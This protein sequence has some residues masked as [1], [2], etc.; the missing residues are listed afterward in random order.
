MV[1]M[2]VGTYLSCPRQKDQ[3]DIMTKI[4][5]SYNGKKEQLASIGK[6]ANSLL[7]QI[8]PIGYHGNMDQMVTML[9]R[10]TD[11]H[12]KREQMTIMD[13]WASWL[14]GQS[15]LTNYHGKRDKV[16]I[17]KRDHYAMLWLVSA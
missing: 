3:A 9:K 8:R 4:P 6:W 7:W 12:A 16:A 5:S 2:V 17:T 13:I 14:S 15:R 1:I 10:T 11:Y